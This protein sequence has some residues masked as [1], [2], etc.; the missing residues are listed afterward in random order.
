MVLVIAILVAVV[1][2]SILI[3][4]RMGETNERSE[5]IMSYLNNFRVFFDEPQLAESSIPS[6]V[7]D[8]NVR[9][10]IKTRIIDTHT[11]VSRVGWVN[12]MDSDEL[13]T[14]LLPLD[15]DVFLWVVFL[16]LLPHALVP[17]RVPAS[18]QYLPAPGERK[19]VLYFRHHGAI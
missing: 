14:W 15:R 17:T 2:G 7:V 18:D 12:V 8:L 13:S 3:K 4:V 9:T 16:P 1:L 6:F 11:F 5:I 10:R 19:Y